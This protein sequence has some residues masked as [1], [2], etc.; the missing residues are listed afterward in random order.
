LR[1]A[2][3]D[4]AISVPNISIPFTETTENDRGSTP[5]VYG[6]PAAR[7]RLIS[8]AAA[9]TPTGIITAA[10]PNSHNPSFMC[11]RTRLTETSAI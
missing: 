2:T 9:S 6:G 5:S 4:A 10:S 1:R 7:S 8:F 11:Q 3:Y